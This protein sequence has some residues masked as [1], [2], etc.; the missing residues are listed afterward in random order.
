MHK[1]VTRCHPSCL[2]KENRALAVRV[3]QW[4][5]HRLRT[6]GPPVRF[7][8]RAHAWVACQVPS[9]VHSRGNHTLMFL[10]LSFSLPS[11]LSKEINNLKKKKRRG[12]NRSGSLSP[13]L[14]RRLRK[15][16]CGGPTWHRLQPVRLASAA[17]ASRAPF[18]PP[19]FSTPSA[20]ESP[21]FTLVKS[22]GKERVRLVG[23]AQGWARV[24]YPVENHSVTFLRKHL[25]G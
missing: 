17:R 8:V 25:G 2:I 22:V 20:S 21:Y 13:V 23:G 12:L 7:P 4:I 5:E 9:E 11:P 3:A 18:T 10:S 6:K 16:V 24:A 15:E 19:A 1:V 14:H